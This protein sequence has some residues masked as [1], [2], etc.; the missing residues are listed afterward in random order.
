MLVAEVGSHLLQADDAVLCAV[1][2]ESSVALAQLFTE[3]PGQG[4][5][6]QRSVFGD[7]TI[8]A[9]IAVADLEMAYG[10]T[11][12]RDEADRDRRLGEWLQSRL[13]RRPVVGD[14]ARI[15][16]IELTVREVR[17]GRIARVGLK[18]SAE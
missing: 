6:T 1:P 16:R 12:A 2:Q 8:D 4:A 15:D 11:L 14:R 17:D 10:F 5:P 3:S 18:L 9:D 7:F 13:R